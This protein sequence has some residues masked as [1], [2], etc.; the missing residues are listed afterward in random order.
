[1][2]DFLTALEK[3]T[4]ISPNLLDGMKDIQVLEAAIIS[5]NT[6]RRVNVSDVK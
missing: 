4:S 3:G 1:V 2:V 5:A 6:G